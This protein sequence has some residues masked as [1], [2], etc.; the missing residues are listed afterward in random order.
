MSSPT[1]DRA[2]VAETSLRLRPRV[3][4]L[5]AAL[6]VARVTV[7][8]LLGYRDYL[9]PNFQ[10]DFL[11]GREGYFWGIYQAA[12]Y[13]HIAAG[14][15]T[16]LLGLVLISEAFR[17]RFA[18]WHRRLGKMQIALI[19]LLLA[20]S[21][22][23]MAWYAEGGAISASGF[24][25]LAIATGS[26]ALL[27]WRAAVQRRFADHRRWMWR[28]YLLLCSAVVLR[29]IGGLASVTQVGGEW[30]YPLAA[31]ASWLLPL[32]VFEIIRAMNRPTRNP[33]DTRPARR[34]SEDFARSGQSPAILR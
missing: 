22:L 2:G 25:L 29:L 10:S 1:R 8:I 32:A 15:V 23:W 6:L 7:G 13:T 18:R 31:W 9:P 26:C 12:F 27:G 24:A 16:L 11:H 30:A 3:V 19:V 34:D 21:G 20:P 4:T 14:P 17:T 33:P 28:C 5:L